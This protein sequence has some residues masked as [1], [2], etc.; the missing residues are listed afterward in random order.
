MERSCLSSETNP[1]WRRVI[2]VG[3]CL[4]REQ[5]SGRFIVLNSR[6]SVCQTI[7]HYCNSICASSVKMVTYEYFPETIILRLVIFFLVLAVQ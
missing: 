5:K 6:M 3:V 1:P 7:K 2:K 4:S